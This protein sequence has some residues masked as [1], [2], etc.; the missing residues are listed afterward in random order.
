[1]FIKRFLLKLS[2]AFFLALV[3]VNCSPTSNSGSNSSTFTS[4][5]Q[6][7]NL[8]EAVFIATYYDFIS[9]APRTCTNCHSNP[10]LSHEIA[11]P[12]PQV[13]FD[14]FLLMSPNPDGSGRAQ[15]A[16][17]LLRA[18]TIDPGH[19]SSGSATYTADADAFDLEWDAVD[20][21]YNGCVNS[22]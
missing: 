16:R 12:D 14:N 21:A 4:L 18:A 19:Q 13:A 8:Y 2:F 6:C 11:I 15:D 22:L 10:G 1:M 20:A 17:A 7:E 5:A 9:T 3:L